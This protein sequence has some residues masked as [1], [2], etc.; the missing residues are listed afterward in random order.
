MKELYY[1]R[2]EVAYDKQIFEDSVF[3]CDS[4]EEYNKV[5]RRFRK[6]LKLY[7]GFTIGRQQTFFNLYG[8]NVNA[9]GF[10]IKSEDDGG[11]YLRFITKYYIKPNA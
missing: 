3:L 9:K 4:I 7:G 11:A 6:E 10:Q 8:I 1:N 2:E 5:L